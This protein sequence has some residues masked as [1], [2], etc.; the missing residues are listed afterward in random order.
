M[1]ILCA[2]LL[3]LTAIALSG[4][5]PVALAAEQLT[6]TTDDGLTLVGQSVT[7]TIAGPFGGGFEDTTAVVRLSGPGRPSVTGHTWPQAATFTQPLGDLT[8]RQTVTVTVPT[9]MPATPGGYLVTVELH[10]AGAP[11]TAGTPATTGTPATA[12]TPATTV[13][14]TILTSGQIWIGKV[15]APDK[16]ID[17]AFVWPVAL[18]VHRDASGAFFDQTLENAVS[19]N[20]GDAGNL[21]GLFAMANEFPDWHFTLGVEPI[22]LAQLSTM[23]SGYTRLDASGGSEQV[24]PGD[25]GAQNA[26]KALAAFKEVANLDNVEIDA[27]PY[28]SPSLGMLATEKWR[29]GFLQ[30]QLGKQEIQDTLGLTSP[31]VGGYPIDLDV[32]TDSLASFAQASIEYAVVDQRL[33]TDLN[34]P[35]AAGAATVRARDLENNRLTLALAS[36]ELLTDMK[37]PWNVDVFFAGLAASLAAGRGGAL[38]ITPGADYT[39]PPVAYLRAIGTALSR[40]PWINTL[41]LGD[42]V[43]ANSPGT[44]PIFLS[45]YTST[46]EGYV[47]ESLLESLRSAHQVVSDLAQATDAVD[48]PVDDAQL[49]L[50]AGE[51]RFWFMPEAGPRLASVGLAYADAADKLAAGELA[52]VKFGGASPVTAWGSDAQL[53]LPV[54]NKAGYP[55]KVVIAVEGSGLNFPKGPRFAVELP[56]GETVVSIPVKASGRSA[57]ASATLTIGTTLVDS[58]SISMRFVTVKTVLPWA[59]AVVVVL[60]IFAMLFLFWRKRR[61]KRKN[62]P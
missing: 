57:K 26:S 42:F 60:G 13:D 58:K 10:P 35:L 17:I 54:E 43:K 14:P 40:M 1:S 33:K 50:Y 22:L 32:T 56:A 16:S 15:G 36:S 19:P 6:L 52:K 59:L 12:G 25:A 11:A 49:L 62:K 51:S 37:P 41:T 46:V 53:R 61:R 30:M 4:G 23:A 27:M 8:G 31:P 2:V 5:A 38:V 20:V 9:E 24:K 3:T 34:E 48:T 7:I 45:R 28:A 47:G 18:G 21:N 29:D 44:R 39:I 55:L